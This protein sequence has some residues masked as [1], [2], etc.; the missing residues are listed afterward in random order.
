M[1]RAHTSASPSAHLD[2]DLQPDALKCI[3]P[4]ESGLTL[5]EIMKASNGEQAQRKVVQ[6]ILNALGNVK[7]HSGVANNPQ[8]GQQQQTALRLAASLADVETSQK[9][10]A[11]A[12][13]AAED[14]QWSKIAP[15]AMQLLKWHVEQGHAIDAKIKLKK[16]DICAAEVRLS[17]PI[18]SSRV[19]EGDGEAAESARWDC[20][21]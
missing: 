7:S 18:P 10:D 17:K 4:T 1:P 19:A 9:A 14:A 6:Q 2:L 3:A 21:C 20:C 12:K 8:R 11:T 5:G 16:E 15:A 13:Q